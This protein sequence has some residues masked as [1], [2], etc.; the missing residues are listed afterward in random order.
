MITQSLIC[1]LKVIIA[2]VEPIVIVVNISSLFL[3]LIRCVTKSFTLTSLFVCSVNDLLVFALLDYVAAG[4]VDHVEIQNES[5]DDKKPK[6]SALISHERYHTISVDLER[7]NL[8]IKLRHDDFHV[9]QDA[10]CFIKKVQIEDHD[11]SWVEHPTFRHDLVNRIS[12]CRLLCF[13][14]VDFERLTVASLLHAQMLRTNE[15][16]RV[17]YEVMAIKWLFIEVQIVDCLLHALIV[18][19]FACF[20]IQ[21]HSEYRHL[22]PWEQLVVLEKEVLFI[23]Y[24]LLDSEYRLNHLIFVSEVVYILVVK[25]LFKLL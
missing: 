20:A 16:V 6:E 13:I 10:S 23:F 15:W 17:V 24:L 4:H 5:K 8:A 22:C 2:D 9:H 19:E 14:I 18:D 12:K 25:A 11:Y 1:T 3:F 7:V 21:I